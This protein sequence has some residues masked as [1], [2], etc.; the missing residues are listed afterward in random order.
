[1]S[2]GLIS[3][4]GN[5]Q[6]S[7]FQTTKFSWA[8]ETLHEHLCVWLHV[9]NCR[10]NMS[11]NIYWTL[12]LWQAC[13]VLHAS[14][15]FHLT[16]FSCRYNYLCYFTCYFIYCQDWKSH[17]TMLWWAF[18]FLFVPHCLPFSLYTSMWTLVTCKAPDASPQLQSVLHLTLCILCCLIFFYVGISLTLSR[19]PNSSK[20]NLT[21]EISMAPPLLPHSVILSQCLQINWC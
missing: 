7:Q 3:L 15:H 16:N 11:P 12:T 10:L 20:I 17:G 8:Q 13:K 19:M 6:L 4:V 1:V 14:F 9:Q 21:C 2:L 5:T 18:C